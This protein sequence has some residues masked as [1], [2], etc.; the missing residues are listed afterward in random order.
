M[1]HSDLGDGRLKICIW[2]CA[3]MKSCNPVEISNTK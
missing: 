3:S 2:A 1:R